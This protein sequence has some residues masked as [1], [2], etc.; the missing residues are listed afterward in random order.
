MKGGNCM[1]ANIKRTI[2]LFINWKGLFGAKW[3]AP[4]ELLN[5]EYLEWQKRACKVYKN[6]GCQKKRVRFWIPRIEE[7]K[8][9]IEIESI[10][11][12][13]S[14]A[15][16]SMQ[17]KVTSTYSSHVI[18]PIREEIFWLA[19]HIFS[20]RCTW[21]LNWLLRQVIVCRKCTNGVLIKWKTRKTYC[22]TGYLR[23]RAYS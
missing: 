10:N 18:L 19:I 16:L 22:F 3:Q 13:T 15:G 5:M 8:N 7:S 23:S 9:T 21:S 20:R 2:N 14:K 12:T 1:A 17:V 11:S 6:M 4:M